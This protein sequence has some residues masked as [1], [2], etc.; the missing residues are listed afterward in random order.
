MTPELL[1]ETTKTTMPFGKYKGKLICDIPEHYLIWFSKK[2]FP[3]GKLGALMQL[4]IEIR[5]NGLEHLLEPL[6]NK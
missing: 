5:I 6:K 3:A 4:M 2:G 1:L